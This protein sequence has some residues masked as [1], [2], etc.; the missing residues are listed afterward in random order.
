ME[1]KRNLWVIPTD[2]P[3]QLYA[4]DGNYKLANSTMAMDWYISSVGYE[5]QNI[6]ITSDEEIR[7]G[8]WCYQVE[9]KD[10]K[11]DKC[12]DVTLYHTWTN[13]GVDKTRKYRKIILTTDQ[14]LV[15]D[16]VQGIDDDFLE[17]FVKNPSY[18][19]V[20]VINLYGD[21]NPIEYFYEII[22]P[23]EEP[24]QET[25]EEAAKNYRDKVGYIKSSELENQI[26]MLGFKEG[27]KWQSEKMYSEED[28]RNAFFNF[29]DEW[30]CFEEWFEQFKKK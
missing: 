1:K 27:A 17:W 18:E 7:E 13:N 9:L 2:K 23:K 29:P 3:S 21:F 10:G 22:I 8:D 25:L 6:Y 30:I 4:K 15:K 28:L 16:G 26:A 5:P 14:D 19:S 12:Y 20:L 11:V 24:K